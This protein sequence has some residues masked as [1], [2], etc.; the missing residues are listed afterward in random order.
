[1]FAWPEHYPPQCPPQAALQ[2]SGTVY[3]FIN[4]R[5]P[6]END[7]A[8]HFEREPS[9]VWLPNECQARGL[10][11]V[12]TLEDCNAMRAGVPALRKKRIAKGSLN[13]TDG[14]VAPTPS[15]TCEGHCTWWRHKAPSE[16]QRIFKLVE[17]AWGASNV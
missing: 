9:K 12:K 17:E 8:S 1:M 6:S 5:I 10:S 14:L 16:V 2:M 3:R 13:T 4:G 7:F 15:K 11:V